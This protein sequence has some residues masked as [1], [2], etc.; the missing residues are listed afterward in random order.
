MFERLVHVETLRDYDSAAWSLSDS[1]GRRIDY[2][3]LSLTDRCN[4]RC[5]YCMPR[6]GMSFIPHNAIL[7]Y[8]ELYRLTGIFASL[9]VR[10]YKVTGGEPFCRKGAASFITELAARSGVDDVTV[11][12]NGSLVEPYLNDLAEG[13]VSAVTF[14][15]DALEET[16]FNRICRV[17]TK[18]QSIFGTMRFAAQLG[19]TVKINTVPL[20]GYNGA[21]LVPLAR[22]A[23]ENGY[24]IRFIELMPVGD[25]ITFSGIPHAE[26]FE[27]MEK[28][29]GTLRPVNRKMGNGPAMVYEVQGYPGFIGFIPAMTGKF[30]EACNRIRLTASGFLKTCLWHGDGVDLRQAMRN[31]ASDAALTNLVIE[32]VNMKPAGHTF[33]FVPSPSQGFYMNS[34]GG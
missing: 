2:L 19:L 24:T 18:A 33:S 25:G 34:V 17:H 6:D 15:C 21:E 20:R 1:A 26:V 29:F 10:H 14:S 22:H 28:F 3:R 13:G 16:T 32:A 11:T 12:T 30:C 27:L 5:L 31:G 8:E 23:L 9:G 4:F 7:S